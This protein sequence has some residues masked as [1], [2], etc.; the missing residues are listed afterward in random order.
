MVKRSETVRSFFE[1]VDLC[2]GSRQIIPCVHKARIVAFAKEHKDF[3][4]FLHDD[5]IF[6][7][8][9]NEKC[10]TQNL[11]GFHS[12]L[13]PNV[14]PFLICCLITPRIKPGF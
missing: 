5:T 7:S 10:L 2:T 11:F 9:L 6:F 14:F 3:T 1:T 4:A 8:R 13:Q 12:V